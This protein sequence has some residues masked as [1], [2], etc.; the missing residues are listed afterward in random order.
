[1]KRI[2]S[3]LAVLALATTAQ[4]V[5][6]TGNQG[7]TVRVHVDF[8]GTYNYALGGAVDAYKIRLEALSPVGSLDYVG[9]MDLAIE[10]VLHQVG[11]YNW[12]YP[13]PP[14]SWVAT[15]TPDLATAAALDWSSFGAPNE[16]W[17]AIDTHFLVNAGGGD[18]VVP[19]PS[20]VYEA[21]EDFDF[22][23]GMNASAFYKEGNGTYLT[24]VAALATTA[25]AQD[26]DFALVV[27]PTGTTGVLNGSLSD[28]KGEE[29]DLG[30]AKFSGSG[31]VIPEPMT[32][33][34]L[35]LGG[36]GLL[37]KRR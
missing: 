32:L 28:G 29:F 3:L 35:A 2:V 25:V 19:P 8:V 11:E 13:P 15:Y 30:A 22:S 33:S 26:L 34:L 37:R 6:I 12:V 21:Q 14:G 27:M 16:D 31:I 23:L 10:G 20:T 5:D 17:T 9:A 7:D 1:M 18:W 4:A 24:V 36:L